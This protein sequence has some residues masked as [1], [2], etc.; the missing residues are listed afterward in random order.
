ME[1]DYDL[2]DI[3]DTVHD[4]PVKLKFPEMSQTSKF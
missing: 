1:L 4:T 2:A 3:V